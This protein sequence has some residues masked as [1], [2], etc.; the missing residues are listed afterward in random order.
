MNT[1]E[2]FEEHEQNRLIQMDLIFREVKN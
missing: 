2:E 1:C